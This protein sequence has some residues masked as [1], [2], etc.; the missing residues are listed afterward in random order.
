MK[1][2]CITGVCQSDL[3]QV[4]EILRQ[5]G[6]KDAR[7]AKRDEA[8]DIHVWHE[9]V[10]AA[11]EESDDPVEG[12]LNPGRLWEQLASDIFLANLKTKCWGWSQTQSTLL[13]DFWAAFDPQL[14]FVL[15]CND[16]EQWLAHELLKEYDEPVEIENLLATWGAYHET[17]LRF[18]H[19]NAER[20]VL[21]NAQ[22][23]LA[24]PQAFIDHLITRW[25]LPLDNFAPNPYSNTSLSPLA[26]HLA[27]QV[28]LEHASYTALKDEIAAT[29]SIFGEPLSTQGLGGWADLF[30]EYRTLAD[31]TAE[32]EQAALASNRQRRIDQLTDELKEANVRFARETSELAANHAKQFAQTK[33][34]FNE[35]NESLKKQSAQLI[36]KLESA[37]QELLD[38]K[39]KVSSLE[40][41]MQSELKQL[42]ARLKDTEEEND[43]LLSQLH[44]VQ[45]ELENYF[46]KYKEAENQSKELEGRISRVTASLRRMAE[47][48]PDYFEFERIEVTPGSEG[49][50]LSWSISGLESGGK[51]FD[52]LE[53]KSVIVNG[54]AGI[55]LPAEGNSLLHRSRTSDDHQ[56]ITLLPT[57]DRK[58]VEQQLDTLLSLSSSDWTW[59]ASL[60]RLLINVLQ[61]PP[62][63][64]VLPKKFVAQPHIMGLKKLLGV[65]TKLERLPNICRFDEVELIREYV[66]QDYESLWLRLTNLC[67]G[68]SWW[69]EFEFRLSCAK[70]PRDSFGL[71]PKLEFPAQS[72]HAFESWFEES[73]DD[74]GARLELRFALPQSADVS[75]WSKLSAKDQALVAALIVRLP[76]MLAALKSDKAR[77]NRPI[78]DWIAAAGS[79]KQL[80][81]QLLAG[82]TAQPARSPEAATI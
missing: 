36:R 33:A 53:F 10:L 76:V 5:A 43:L 48:Y 15:V 13:L 79:I 35:R 59:F 2:L 30:A 67:L 66:N 58:F 70:V 24:N 28:V 21:I 4:A 37:Q 41:R 34:D 75:V 25:K 31:R 12:L 23:S 14:Q 44:Q 73:S 7:P 6:M 38:Y 51:S 29:L 40:S 17:L 22:N 42:Q 71:H 32:A 26:L 74:L 77:L 27:K 61:D 82:S 9:Q 65:L 20:C 39:N 49:I 46:L 63:K 54:V 47:R 45:E 11:A 52:R 50:G 19:R 72:K 56:E 69:R 62:N 78:D 81:E 68:D 80:Y 64:L 18:Y 55:M 1:S 3:E 60:P 8:I 57:G 16:P